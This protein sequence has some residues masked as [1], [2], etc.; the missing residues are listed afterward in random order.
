MIATHL[1]NRMPSS[2]LKM[3][4]PFYSLQKRNLDYNSLRLFGCRC[5]PYL[6]KHNHNKF[7]KKTYPCIFVGHSPNH[8]GYKCLDPKTNWVCISRHVVFEEFN[9]PF[10]IDPKQETTIGEILELITFPEAEAWTNKLANVGDPEEVQNLVRPTFNC[11][12]KKAAVDYDPASPTI[13]Y[14]NRALTEEINCESATDR[15]T[16]ESTPPTL[17]CCDKE[18]ANCNTSSSKTIQAD[19]QHGSNVKFASNSSR[20]N[21][22]SK[23]QIKKINKSILVIQMALIY[24]LT[25]IFLR[26]LKT[27]LQQKRNSQTNIG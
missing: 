2:T 1:I 25:Q 12:T 15:N 21:Q 24:L 9:L 22:I 8:K 13:N 14:V 26:S 16:T 11:E 27:T 6:M 18:V 4:T 17:T 5:F 23:Q 10:V 20:Q 3:E 19:I 7:E